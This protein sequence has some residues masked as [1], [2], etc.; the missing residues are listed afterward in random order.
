MKTALKIDSTDV[1]TYY[2]LGEAYFKKGDLDEAK[3]ILM[4]SLLVDSS[5]YPSSKLLNQICD[6]LNSYHG[7]D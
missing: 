7:S 4:K 3:Q 2:K 6:S 1:R 5:Y